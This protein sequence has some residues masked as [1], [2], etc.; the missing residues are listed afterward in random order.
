MFQQMVGCPQGMRYRH[1]GLPL[2]SAAEGNGCEDGI[3]AKPAE[4]KGEEAV[5]V[6]ARWLQQEEGEEQGAGENNPGKQWGQDSEQFLEAEK[7][8]GA[9]D[10][11]K[12]KGFRLKRGCEQQAEKKDGSRQ[13]RMLAERGA[14]SAQMFPGQYAPDETEADNMVDID[15]LHAVVS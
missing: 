8:P 13:Q 6:P 15:P 9:I 5:R 14:V 3:E 4:D 7:K 1:K 2:G 12:S 11:Q 10:V